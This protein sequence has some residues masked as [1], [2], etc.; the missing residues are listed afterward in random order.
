MSREK[1]SFWHKTPPEAYEVVEESSRGMEEI[2]REVDGQSP[3][4]SFHV[5][6]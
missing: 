2:P 4:F 5:S 6:Q 1:N 3:V